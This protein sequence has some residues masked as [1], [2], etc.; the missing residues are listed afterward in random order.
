[1]SSARG[2]AVREAFITV[3]GSGYSPVASGT[4]GAAASAALFVPVWAGLALAGA[5]RLTVEAVAAVCVV[6]ASVLSVRWGKWAVERFN[7]SDPKPFVLDEFA[8]QWISLMFLPV[9][10]SAPLA[11]QAAFIFGQFLLF[12][13]FDILKPPPARQFEKL[14]DG[15]GVLTDD[16][17]AG[18]YANIAGQ[19]LWRL[20][21]LPLWLAGVGAGAGGG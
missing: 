1:M 21:P 16:L 7:S 9:A 15:W 10:F 18:L 4:V 6:S 11:T 14:P 3:L 17:F 13:V 5:P 2:D 12:R 20:T 8:G 19:L